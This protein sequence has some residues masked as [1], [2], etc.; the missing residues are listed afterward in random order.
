MNRF[1]KGG[2]GVLLAVASVM[3][4]VPASAQYYG[5]RDSDRD[6]V[7]DRRE[8]N[9]DR[10]RDGRPDQFDRRDDRR[11][12]W[13]GHRDRDHRWR[14]YG[15]HYGYDGYRGAW[16]SG[17]RYPYWRDNSYVILDYGA[18]DLPP[19]RPGY[20]YYRDR[21]GDIVMA[22]VASGIIGL[23]IGGALADG[24]HHRGW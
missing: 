22:A 18:Y 7:P 14:Y 2:M 1:L 19:P 3:S 11:G 23:I 9:R 13:R 6:G 4:A 12:D 17:Q 16:R 10:D 24:G 21:N 20:R 5:G 8:W 15:G